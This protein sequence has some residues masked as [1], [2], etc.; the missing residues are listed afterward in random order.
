[1][2]VTAAVA[3]RLVWEMTWLRWHLGP[4]RIGASLVHGALA[5]LLWAPP[6]LLLWIVVFAVRMLF[7]RSRERVIA[8]AA[9][10]WMAAALGVMGVLALPQSFY[11]A[12][13][14]SELARSLRSQELFVAAA[15]SGEVRAVRGMLDRG[16]SVNATN[17]EGST[18]LHLAA[19]TGQNRVVEL[20]LQRGANVNAVDHYGGSP[21]L[22]AN[23]AKHED[24][25]KLLLAHGARELPAAASQQ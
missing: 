24:T 11:D 8:G 4:Q 16:V 2:V 15:G 18:A 1:M 10:V 19:G 9:W 22:S 5:S 7:W 21:L 12:V 6:L 13:F 23:D 14:V 25:A 3:L 17:S 20:L